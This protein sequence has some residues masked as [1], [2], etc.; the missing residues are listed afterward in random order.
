MITER[1][2]SGN[3]RDSHTLPI[4]IASGGVLVP[5]CNDITAILLHADVW[6]DEAEPESERGN[7][8]KT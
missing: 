3:S 4:R 5:G 1:S 7:L 8:S 2:C 6:K